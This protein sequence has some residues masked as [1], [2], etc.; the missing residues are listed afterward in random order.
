M[1]A[2]VLLDLTMVKMAMT[3][4]ITRLSTVLLVSSVLVLSSIAAV[5]LVLLATNNS[6]NAAY[7]KDNCEVTETEELRESVCSGGNG[8]GPDDPCCVGGAG[9]RSILITDQSTHT[10]TNINSGGG[11]GILRDDSGFDAS[12]AGGGGHS[13]SCTESLSTGEEVCSRLVVGRGSNP[14]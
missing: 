7:A 6:N 11:G 12:S 9:S 4:K 2:V 5:Q 13:Q 8:V 3:T 14:H 1:L 10:E